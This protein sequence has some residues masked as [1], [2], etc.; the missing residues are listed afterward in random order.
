VTQ[1]KR[2]GQRY[3]Q[4]SISPQGPLDDWGDGMQ[5]VETLD[6]LWKWLPFGGTCH[7]DLAAGV[8]ESGG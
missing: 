3:P 5:S 2:E 8:D 1:E 4:A 7:F 6:G